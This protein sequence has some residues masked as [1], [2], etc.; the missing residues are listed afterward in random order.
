MAQRVLKRAARWH[1]ARGAANDG[2]SGLLDDVR[3]L[4]RGANVAFCNLETPVLPATTDTGIEAAGAE[5]PKFFGPTA[6]VGAL[7]DA[8]FNLLGV[9]NN[10]AHDMGPGGI[11]GTVE[12]LHKAALSAA[13][14][15]IDGTPRPGEIALGRWTVRAIGATTK[16]NKTLPA[17]FTRWDVQSV[18]PIDAGALVDQVKEAAAPGQACVVS[19][20]WGAEWGLRPDQAQRDLARRLCDAG[21]VLVLGHHAHVAQSV[22]VYKAKDG[23][24]CLIAWSL[25]NLVAFEPDH[26]EANLGMVLRAELDADAQGRPRVAA[27]SWQPTWARRDGDCIRIVPLD[28]DTDAARQALA[29]PECQRQLK[30]AEKRVGPRTISVPSD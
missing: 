23:R 21:A 10:H 8:G 13:G 29:D 17:G 15:V 30:A 1:A 4:V 2:W 12:T 6:L 11:D 26:V 18:D 20:H 7:R 25:G 9:A 19:M 3:P 24:I 28:S 16:M 14:F 22:E 27:A 5:Y